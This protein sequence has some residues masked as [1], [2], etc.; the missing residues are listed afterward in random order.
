MEYEARK[1]PAAVG[2]PKAAGGRRARSNGCGGSGAA[3]A[4]ATR[5]SPGFALVYFEFN[6]Q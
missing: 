4:R 5:G 3:S 6:E 1:S 2:P